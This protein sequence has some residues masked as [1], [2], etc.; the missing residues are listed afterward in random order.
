MEEDLSIELEEYVSHLYGIKGQNINKARHAIF[1]AKLEKQKKICDISL[2][3]PCKQALYF[4]SLR[5]NFIAHQLR[6][7]L[8]PESQLGEVVDNGWTGELEP[9]W[10]ENVMPADIKELFV[11]LEWEEYSEDSDE[12]ADED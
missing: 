2:L 10:L 4:H 7:S 1:N 12:S 9:K 5:A 3:P 8:E 6:T 11:N